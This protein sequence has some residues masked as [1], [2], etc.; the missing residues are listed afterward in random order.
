MGQYKLQELPPEREPLISR[1]GHAHFQRVISDAKLADEFLKDAGIIDE[2]G[3][4]AAPYRIEKI[5]DSHGKEAQT[6]MS[7]ARSIDRLPRL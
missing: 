7:H 5:K 2:N 3:E 4:L 1:R 6:S